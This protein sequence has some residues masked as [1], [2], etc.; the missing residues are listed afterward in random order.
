MCVA[1]LA[2]LS[3]CGSD[4]GG[5]SADSV[6]QAAV[7]DEEVVEAGEVDTAT[8]CGVAVDSASDADLAADLA[9]RADSFRA[10]AEKMPADLQAALRTAADA[11]GKLAQASKDDPTGG[12]LAKLVEELSG[13]TALTEAQQL[14]EKTVAEKCT[15]TEGEE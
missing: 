6:E 10:V 5:S 9:A 3:A 15:S 1:M 11:M 4:D 13:D 8:F 14:I 12:E 7:V 2:L